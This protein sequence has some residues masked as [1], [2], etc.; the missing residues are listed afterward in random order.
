MF[1]VISKKLVAYE[2]S[3]VQFDLPLTL[4]QKVLSWGNKNIPDSDLYTAKEKYGRED[5]IHVTVKYG[6]HTTDVDEIKEIV[7]GFGP[8]QIKL[9]KVSRF[10]PKE[11]E[12]DVVKIDIESDELAELHALLGELEN[13]DEHPVYHPHCTVAYVKKGHCIDLS[14]SSD[15]EGHT[16]SVQILSFSSKS[17]QKHRI[18]V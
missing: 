14:G 15:L 10:V 3:S 8:F 7:E 9:G 16:A 13:S 1:I 4:S 11:K 6:L 17:G 2:F 5:E 12:Y 18:H